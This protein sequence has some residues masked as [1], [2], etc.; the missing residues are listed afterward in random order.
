MD[1]DGGVLQRTFW[2]SHLEAGARVGAGNSAESYKDH[3]WA[4]EGTVVGRRAGRK[5]L[6][7]LKVGAW[8][9]EGSPSKRCRKY[10]VGRGYEGRGHNG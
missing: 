4:G 7:G 6:Q 3:I 2:N 1:S 5:Y 10:V 8:G 9:R